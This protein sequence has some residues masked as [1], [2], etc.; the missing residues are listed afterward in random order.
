[1]DGCHESVTVPKSMLP[2]NLR[3]MFNGEE[4]TVSG[5][6]SGNHSDEVSGG[7][8]CSNYIPY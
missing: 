7:S 1:M 6:I 5:L 2:E 3:Y 8:F 4:I